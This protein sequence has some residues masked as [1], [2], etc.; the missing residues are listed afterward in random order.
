MQGFNFSILPEPFGP[1][2]LRLKSY[3]TS[4]NLTGF[5]LAMRTNL[6]GFVMFIVTLR[7]YGFIFTKE[8]LTGPIF[9]ILQAL[10]GSCF[11]YVN[12]LTGLL[13]LFSSEKSYGTNLSF[14][15]FELGLTG[16]VFL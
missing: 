5:F 4:K 14:Q 1:L 16:L 8:G 7:G 10:R 15:S 11:Q 9:F 6:T 13:V 2:W 12:S 3:G